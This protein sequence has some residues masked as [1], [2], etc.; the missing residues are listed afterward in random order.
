LITGRLQDGSTALKDTAD[1]SVGEAFKIASEE[2][3]ITASN[4]IYLKVFI[5]SGSDHSA[6]RS[7]H[8]RCITT[9]GHY[10]NS[11]HVVVSFA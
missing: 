9:A 2:T 8:A 4:A 1:L 3:R 7:I 11:F 6:D 10:G 5:N